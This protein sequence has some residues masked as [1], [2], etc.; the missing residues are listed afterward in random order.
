MS[1]LGRFPGYAAAAAPTAG[2]G[3]DTILAA[4][5][6]GASEG[7]WYEDS[8]TGAAFR[9]YAPTG[10]QG[11]LVPAALYD[12]LDA[13]VANASGNAE[14]TLADD[15]DTDND[16]TDR[17]WVISLGATGVFSK[18][19]DAAATFTSGTTAG[20]NANPQFT[21]T[22]VP[23]RSLVILRQTLTDVNTS[24][25]GWPLYVPC[26]A[27]HY[28]RFEQTT[29]A[30]DGRSRLWDGA[31]QDGGGLIT[32]GV[33]GD[34]GTIFAVY[35]G[36]DADANTHLWCLETGEHIAAQRDQIVSGAISLLSYNASNVGGGAGG[37]SA[38]SIEEFHWIALT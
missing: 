15:E 6:A 23:T 14:W 28:A 20:S 19:G 8:Q 10:T 32:Q 16:L 7:D 35:D 38:G 22:A 37:V 17:G 4:A 3:Y 26:G 1:L 11:V 9:F 18:V 13:Y 34:A 21:P 36:T 29:S 5:R 31:A 33:A 25:G 30:A 2:A 12:L 24:D 27:S